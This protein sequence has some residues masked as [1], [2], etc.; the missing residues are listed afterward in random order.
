MWLF[1][2]FWTEA[3]RS[4][5]PWAELFFRGVTMLGS[6]Y[7]Y[8]VLVAIWFWAVDK[9]GAI[10]AVFVLIVSFVS[11]YWLKI[12][13]KNPRPPVTNWLS[14]VNVSSYSLPSGHAQNSV[15][16][17]SW[18]GLKSRT[19][20]MGVLSLALI[21]LVGLSRVYMGV[22]W[23]GDVVAGWAVGILILIALWRLE[24]PIHSFLSKYNPNLQYL[25]VII[26]GLGA[27]ILTEFLSPLTVEGLAANFG[28]NG[29]LIIGLGIGLALEKRYVNFEITPKQGEKWRTA[30]RVILG[31]MMVFAIAASLS[32]MLPEEVYWMGA[33]HYA[34]VTIS[35]IFIWP[36]LFKKLGL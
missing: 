12:I 28:P 2:V 34:L 4:L 6:E 10:L 36:L 8:V 29:G 27:M 7:F 19:W 1:D 21:G 22:H 14:G 11:N 18:I 17:W 33:I 15:V 24:E 16:I 23:L 35:V 9:R 32:P 31:L 20:W 3:F 26:F 13:F 25:G 5:M 30:L